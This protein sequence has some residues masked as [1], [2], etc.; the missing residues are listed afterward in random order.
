MIVY[1]VLCYVC[2]DMSC[3]TVQYSVCYMVV[4]HVMLCYVMPHPVMFRYV[5]PCCFELWYVSWSDV[6]Y[7]VYSEAGS[8]TRGWLSKA[9]SLFESPI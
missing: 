7:L 5:T 8:E 6:M 3:P 9:W 1:F 4:C 2:H